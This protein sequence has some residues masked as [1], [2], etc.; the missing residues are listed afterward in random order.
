MLA[1]LVVA[2][3]VAKQAGQKIVKAHASQTMYL[4]NG[5][6]MATATMVRIF[7]LISVVLNVPQA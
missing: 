7:L 3:V 4:K 6:A 5:L 1:T 2:A